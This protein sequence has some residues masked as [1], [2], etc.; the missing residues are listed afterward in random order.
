L[1]KW[2]RSQGSASISRWLGAGLL[3]ST[4]TTAGEAAC[5]AAAKLNWTAA[6]GGAPAAAG[7]VGRT[8]GAS[9]SHSGLS[10]DTTK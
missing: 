7:S 10:V 1:P 5:A 6:L 8:R 2:K 4:A 9:C 3:A